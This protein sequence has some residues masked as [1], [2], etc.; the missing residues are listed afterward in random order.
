M[1]PEPENLIPELFERAIERPPAEREAFLRQACAGDGQLFRAV[2]SLVASYH[3]N[4]RFLET[5]AIGEAAAIFATSVGRDSTLDLAEGAP[6][7]AGLTVGTRLGKYKITGHLGRGG[8]GEVFRAHDADLGR[9]VAIK[10]LPGHYAAAR[11]RA[12]RFERE[13]RTLAALNHPN[14]AHIHGREEV[15]GVRF[16]AMEYVPGETLAARI[17]RAPLHAGEALDVFRQMADA[18]AA[19]HEAGVL[20]RDLKPANVMLTPQGR[21]KLLDFG[22]AK[23]FRDDAAPTFDS[24]ARPAPA[25]TVVTLTTPGS[26]PGTAAYMS[27]E[28]C[29]GGGEPPDGDARGVDLW[30]FGLV[31][32]EALTGSHPFRADTREATKTAIRSREPDWGKLPAAVPRKIEAL[33]R[34]CLEKD[35]RRRLRDAREAERLIDEALHPSPL[36]ALKEKYRRASLKAKALSVT[37]ALLALV[38]AGWLAF[39]FPFSRA[40]AAPTRLAVIALTD[41]EERQACEPGPSKALARLLQDRL[42]DVRGVRLV[43]GAETLTASGRA[44]PLLMTDLSGPQAARTAGADT[45]LRVGAACGDGGAGGAQSFKYSLVTRGGETIASGVETDFRRM[46]ASV[47]GALSV[48]PAAEWQVPDAEQRYYQ[49]LA[50]LDQYAS[51]QAVADVLR[52]LEELKT[53]D[54]VDRPRVLSA[55]GLGW[56]LKYN[57]TRQ[58]E[59]KDR[60]V[61]SCDQVSSSVSPDALTRCGVVLTATGHAEKAVVNFES[62]LKQRPDD[63]DAILGLAEAHE[64]RGDTAKAEE[65]YKQAALLRPDYWAVYNELGGFYFE[66]A[67]YKSAA[68]A[69]RVVTD[70]LPLN[71]YGWSNL[72][73]AQLYQA[74]FAAAEVSFEHSIRQRRTLEGYQNLGI[75]LLYAGR[76]AE[77]AAAFAE[78]AK[79]AADDAEVQGWLGDAAACDPARRDEAAAA[80]DRAIELMNKR[81]L[82]EPGVPSNLALRSEWLAKR[83]RNEQAIAHLTKALAVAPEEPFTALSAV[84]VYYLAGRAQQALEFVPRAAR[85]ASSRFDLEHAPELAGLRSNPAYRSAV[86]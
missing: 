56:Y 74:D 26:T 49:A 82:A 61:A 62:A 43:P 2:F 46:L 80:Y 81:L 24:A 65:L 5:P 44:L 59:D 76:C 30:A 50:S 86:E 7:A 6:G 47:L 32:Y 10:I 84:K 12:L 52:T 39:N 8:M 17:G 1:T 55:L 38:G 40:N 85:H 15:G 23:H 29:G 58:T 33:L 54:A 20:H 9:D 22:I 19:T 37:A 18:L 27:P 72:G 48:N 31:F 83:G 28:L 4:D 41:A 66:R 68:E 16:I 25:D 3:E 11:E 79:L 36:T 70:L 14:I 21:V 51:E 73:S 64:H 77:A 71:P 78:G 34:A 35:P 67:R 13:A 57:L 75:A 53:Q 42:R 45:V 60:A 69:W 63:A